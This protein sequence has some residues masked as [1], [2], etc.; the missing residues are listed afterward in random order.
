MA[1]RTLKWRIELRG[2][3]FVHCYDMLETYFSS[4][5]EVT[6]KSST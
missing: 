2:S 4:F 5:L 1:S 6:D 3:A